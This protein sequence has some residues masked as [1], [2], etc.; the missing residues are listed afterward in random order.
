MPN[1][2]IYDNKDSSVGYLKIDKGNGPEQD[3]FPD[4][5]FIAITRKDELSIISSCSHLGITNIVETALATFNLPLGFIVGGFHIKDCGAEHYAM[6]FDYL[7]K[8]SPKQIG[9]CH[10]T[11]IEKY[12]EMKQ[13][14]KAKVFYNS[15]G[16]QLNM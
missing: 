12:E 3:H 5:L 15:T 8:V 16:H 7:N 13:K 4:E 11:G 1:T 10:C 6:I 9:V 14:C 2:T